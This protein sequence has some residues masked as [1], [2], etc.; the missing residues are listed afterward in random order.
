M[1]FGTHIGR[2]LALALLSLCVVAGAARAADAPRMAGVVNV[3]TATVEE[4]QIL[5]GIGEARARELV[6]LR[7]Q[8]GGFKSVDELKEVKGI[9]DASLER[10]RP[11]VRLEGKT[12]ARI[13]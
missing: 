6:A 13:E 8:R 3:N 4:L 10:L 9:G 11:F 1:N 5:P 7:K 2:V 12:T